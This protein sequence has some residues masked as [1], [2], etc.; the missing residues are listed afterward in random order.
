MLALGAGAIAAAWGA[1]QAMPRRAAAARGEPGPLG[2]GAVA[3]VLGLGGLLAVVAPVASWSVLLAALG[4]AASTL[5]PAAVLTCW[6]ERLSA[7]AV[8]IGAG[9]GCLVFAGLAVLGLVAP[10]GLTATSW[11][12]WLAAWPTVLALP[13]NAVVAWL[14]SPSSAPAARGALPADLATLHDDA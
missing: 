6:R 10:R 13:A 5:A 4:L 11:I 2:G 1:L 8:V 7:R 12:T 9:V 3:L 14:L